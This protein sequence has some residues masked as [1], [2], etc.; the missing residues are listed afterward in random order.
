MA[1]CGDLWHVGACCDNVVA[2][3]GKVVV[4]LWHVVAFCGMLW[5]VVACC[6]DVVTMLKNVVKMLW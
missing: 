5:H 3:Y 6:G 4:M 1:I 2:Y